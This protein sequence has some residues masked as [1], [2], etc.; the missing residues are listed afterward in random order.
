MINTA[1]RYSHASPD[2]VTVV[3]MSSC[4]KCHCRKT[5]EDGAVIESRPLR[6]A[7]SSEIVEW[8]HGGCRWSSLHASISSRRIRCKA[9]NLPRSWIISC[10]EYRAVDE[11][12]VSPTMGTF[13]ERGWN[14]TDWEYRWSVGSE[15]GVRPLQGIKRR[16][17]E[18]GRTG[19]RTGG[20]WMAMQ[21]ERERVARVVRAKWWERK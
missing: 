2:I 15:L 19:R 3:Y 7:M 18:I 13:Q 16:T 5:F 8:S 20:R 21:L 9:T 12:S 14:A 4:E 17:G 1:K 6:Y 11:F 10:V